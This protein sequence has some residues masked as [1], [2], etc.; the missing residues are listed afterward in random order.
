MQNYELREIIKVGDDKEIAVCSME[1]FVVDEETDKEYTYYQVSIHPYING[2]IVYEKL[3]FITYCI[4]KDF[5]AQ[6]HNDLI[7]R[8]KSGDTSDINGGYAI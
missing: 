3:L 8:I 1:V 4:D 5:M 7:T 2:N 6:F